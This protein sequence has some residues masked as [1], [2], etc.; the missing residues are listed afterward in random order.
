MTTLLHL[1]LFPPENGRAGLHAS[2]HS[3][4]SG[5]AIYLLFCVMQ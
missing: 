1:T 2:L 3:P 5:F 4:A